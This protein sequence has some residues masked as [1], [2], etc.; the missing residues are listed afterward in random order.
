MSTGVISVEKVP[1]TDNLTNMMTK[2][3]VVSKFKHCMDLISLRS[4]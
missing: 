1:S 3:L 4:V 2:P